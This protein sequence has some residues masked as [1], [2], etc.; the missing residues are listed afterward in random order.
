MSYQSFCYTIFG[1]VG[2]NYRKDKKLGI[3]LSKAHMEM[4]PDAYVAWAT[5]TTLLI[6][7]VA[8]IIGLLA[9]AVFIPLFEDST[10]QGLDPEDQSYMD[11]G[12]KTQIFLGVW[13]GIT[14]SAII[15]FKGI[16]FGD[17]TLK[18]NMP[19]M[20]AKQRG[21]VADLYLPHAASYVAA[22]AASNSTMDNI[23]L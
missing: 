7:V 1:F 21:K 10:N 23:F 18:G 12:T 9:H 16:S 5:T 6:S 11:S 4:T 22:L 8:L 2:K 3:D 19:A 20:K 15:Y 14:F 17:F 13:L